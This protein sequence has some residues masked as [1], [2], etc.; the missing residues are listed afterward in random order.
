MPA[1]SLSVRLRSLRA[2]KEWTMEQAARQIGTTV[3]NLSRIEKGA[4]HPRLKTLSRIARAYGVSVE[5]LISL[6][7]QQ[8]P[9]AL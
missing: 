2:A 1:P 8:L 3:D 9:L 6:E 5:E 4:R 7:D